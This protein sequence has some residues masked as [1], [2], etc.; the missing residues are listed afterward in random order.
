M[1]LFEMIRRGH[2]AGETIHQLARKH[3]VHRR[4]VRQALESAVP[5]ERK[6]AEREQPKLGPV[7]E[8]IDRIL[9]EDQQAPRKQRHTA[10]RIWARLRE[11]K[12]AHEIGEATV[13]E[14]V[15]L[16]KGQMGVNG[17][18]VFV[19]Q[20]YGLG[21]E[22]QVDWFE[23][24][25][26]LDGEM[27]RLQ[28]F[29]MRSMGSG[30]AFHRAYT[31][32]T[33]QAFLEGHEHGFDYFGGVFHKLRY[34]NLTIAVKKILRGR[35]REETDRI[36]AFRSHWGFQSEYCNP[37]R[38]NEKGGVEGEL[39]WYRRNFLVPV[40]EAGDLAGLNA[41]LLEKCR[42]SQQHTISGRT[43]TIGAAME[44][45]RPHLLPLA[46]ER[47]ALEEILYPVVDGKG[48]VRVKTNWYSTPLDAGVRA[49]VKVWPSE[50]EVYRD[51][52]CV[53]RHQRCYGRG[54]QLL[55][56]EHY[57][58][59]LEK[60]PGAMAG[61]T[62]LAQWRAAG[63]WPECLD[64]IWGK[65]EAR[66]GKSGG[67]REMIA[68]VR[69][70]LSDGW[71]KLIRAVEEALRLGVT[72]AAAVTHILR[73]PDPEARRRYALRLAEELAEFERPLPVMD[74]YDLLL[75][76]TEVIQ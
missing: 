16:R 11:E 46:E 15:H 12:P 10:H 63:R 53:A 24:A 34:D 37:A 69:T 22:G 45:E 29:A 55:N 3:K 72:D 66:H 75:G 25:A 23:G 76:D 39:G 48:C 35:Q 47:F 71:E 7:K 74:E 32:A 49:M 43:M 60:K 54:H 5:P 8:Y 31:N 28:F 27:C 62:P 67:T 2:A 33:Q 18:E 61:S 64:A 73:M 19:P 52:A 41:L 21:Q 56:L 51:F 44:Q 1:E 26:R 4:T 59:V 9:K 70:G 57:L 50:V 30:G 6:K 38:G 20:S 65:L 17:R 40:P 14:Y 68:L 42:A 36:I 13:R 58:D